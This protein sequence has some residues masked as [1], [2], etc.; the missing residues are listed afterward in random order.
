MKKLAVVGRAEPTGLGSMMRDFVTNMECEQV[1]YVDLSG[2]SNDK[3]TKMV[4]RTL[5]GTYLDL[6]NFNADLFLNKLKNVDYVVFFETTYGLLHLCKLAGKKVI[7]FPMAECS[8]DESKDCDVVIAL[9][10]ECKKRFPRSYRMEWPIDISGYQTNPKTKTPLRFVHN[11][12]FV[13]ANNRNST[14]LVIRAGEWLNG[15]ESTLTVHTPFPLPTSYV[16]DVNCKNVIIEEGILDPSFLYCDCDV[17]VM[18]QKFETP[19]L[20]VLECCALGIPIIVSDTDRNKDFPHRVMTTRSVRNGK[21]FP[22]K[23]DFDINFYEVNE[24][25]LGATMFEMAI[26]K[27]K[28]VAYKSNSNTWSSFSETLTKIL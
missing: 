18:P 12:G 21:D 26:G 10:D 4:D 8:S 6:A 1:F 24:E 16:K 11:A 19:S 22:C 27:V 13:G 5:P 17:F 2:V 3:R 20:S 25:S 14:D 23:A 28:P 7:I 9:A 15:T